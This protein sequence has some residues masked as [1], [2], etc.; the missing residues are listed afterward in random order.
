[1]SEEEWIMQIGSMHNSQDFYEFIWYYMQTAIGRT[2]KEYLKKRIDK[3]KK[4]KK[5]IYKSI[6]N[7]SR[8]LR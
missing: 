5:N 7:S 3:F 1:M 6:N 8:N 4:K 2:N